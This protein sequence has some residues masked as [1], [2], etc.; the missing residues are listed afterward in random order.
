M[1]WISVTAKTT[2]EGGILKRSAGVPGQQTRGFELGSYSQPRPIVPTLMFDKESPWTHPES[3]SSTSWWPSP[4]MHQ[5]QDYDWVDRSPL[6]DACA[7]SSRR[8]YDD[9]G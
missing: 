4:D 7:A 3:R 9:C 1:S 8:I 2:I 5:G 6:R